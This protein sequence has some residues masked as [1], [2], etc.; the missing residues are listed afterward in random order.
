MV[1]VVSRSQ[2]NVLGAKEE[3]V[4]KSHEA[5]SSQKSEMP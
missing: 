5:K 2:T 3:I 4:I 1:N